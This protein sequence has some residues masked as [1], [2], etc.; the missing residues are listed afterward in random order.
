MQRS[1]NIK[2]VLAVTLTLVVIAVIMFAVFMTDT[3]SGEGVAGITSNLQET[4]ESSYSTDSPYS[5]TIRILTSPDIHS[6]IFAMSEN[7]TGSRIGRIGA[8]ANSLGNERED[9]LYLFAG[10]L[11]EGNFYHTYAGVPEVKAYSMAGVDLAVPGNHAFDF[12]TE[13]FESGVTNA[14]YSVICANLDFTDSELNNIIRDYAVFNAGGAK[15]GVFGIITPQLGKIVTIPEDMIF[16]K[17]TTD[18]GNSAVKSLKNEGADIIIALTHESREEDLKLAE[19]VS[20]IDL[21]IGGHDHLVW[22]ETITGGDGGETLIVHAGKYG[23]EMDCVDIT[24]ED[25]ILSDASVVRYTITEDM[26]DDEEITSFVMP[27]YNNYSD[28]LSN[29]IGYSQVALDVPYLEIRSKET[30]AGDLITDTIKDNVPGVDIALINSGSIRG[31]AVIP[32][33][34]ISYLTLNTI[35]PFENMIVTIRMTGQEI[36]DTLERSASA[37]VVSGDECPGEERVGSGGFLQVSGVRFEINTKGD[38]FCCDYDNDR[39][40]CTGNRILNL[41]VVT[42]SG[43]E[44][45]VPDK[46]YTVAVNNYM[47]GGGDGYTNLLEIADDKKYNTE[48]NLIGLLA[49]AIERDSPISPET[50]GRILVFS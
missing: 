9:T 2:P 48:I 16:Y 39:V 35:L 22:N 6:H 41:S 30:N 10:D 47:A 1:F 45:I 27:Y 38:V 24:F 26:P 36:R 40:K 49:A 46:T 29:P 7:D 25:G 17:N 15:V 20:G 50:D 11:G 4:A 43:N 28:S 42:D 18:I 5:G 37:I 12:S 32:A 8:L 19:S 21:I 33:G 13:V 31:D 34:E 3:D 44:P 14:S 23:E